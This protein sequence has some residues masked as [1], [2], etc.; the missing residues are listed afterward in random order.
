M[1]TLFGEDGER[2]VREAREIDVLRRQWK[3]EIR[4]GGFVE[5]RGED[6]AALC[7]PYQ[8]R[9]R[10]AERTIDTLHFL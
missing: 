3:V 2:E 5:D 9:V 8:S 1:Q 10:L 6:E 7:D 4:E